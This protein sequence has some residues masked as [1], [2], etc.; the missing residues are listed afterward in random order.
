MYQVNGIVIPDWQDYAQPHVLGSVTGIG[1]A[2]VLDGARESC[3][4]P[5]DMG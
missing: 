3:H 1:H 5:R 4:Q 2:T